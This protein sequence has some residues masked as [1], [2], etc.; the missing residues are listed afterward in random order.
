MWEMAQLRRR[1]T[2]GAIRKGKFMPIVIMTVTGEP[3]SGCSVK[4]RGTAIKSCSPLALAYDGANPVT[5]ERSAIFGIQVDFYRLKS[6]MHAGAEYRAH[7]VIAMA[8]RA[9][10]AKVPR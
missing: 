2:S 8:K 6:D 1:F 10:K 9:V 7:P 4:A 5:I 3:R